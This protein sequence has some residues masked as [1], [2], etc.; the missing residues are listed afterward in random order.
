MISIWPPGRDVLRFL[1]MDDVNS[2]S[3]QVITYRFTRVVFGVSCSPFLLKA[4]L[5]RHIESYSE[6]H[7]EICKRLVNS[8]YV[9]DVN[10]GGYSVEE[11][12][13]LFRVSRQMM[14]EGGFNLRKWL[15]NSKEMMSQIKSSQNDGESEVPNE[16][17]VTE[18]DQSFAKTVLNVS[19]TSDGERVKILGLNWNSDT[20]NIV[21]HLSQLA[22][23]IIERPV[24]K[25][26][27][28]SLIA[29]IFDPLGLITPATTPL[30][31]FLQKLF[32]LKIGWD[33]HLR[34]ELAD[35][36]AK[37]HSHLMKTKEISVPRYHFG[38]LEAKPAEIE[39]CGFCDSSKQSYAAAVYA[40]ITV[41]GKSSVSLV[42]SKSRVAPLAKTTIPRLELLSALILARL[43]TSVK[44]ALSPLFCNV[45]IM[46]CWTDSITAMYWIKGDEKQWKMFVD[47]CVQEIRKLVNKDLWQ[48][49]PGTENPADIPTRNNDPSRLTKDSRWFLAPNG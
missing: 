38:S 17:D 19:E 44:D 5:S 1:W 45:K 35:E 34:G 26:T 49:C 14:Q 25:R 46:R 43:I 9:D 2:S 10:R 21:F 29:K 12:M 24:T 30:K 27:I 20:D 47:N 11:V 8:L 37:L 40:K 32:Q 15:S 31:V 23:T 18:E 13:E 39:L 6:N 28:L 3:P 16:P 4:T 48:H 33:E 42:M 41:E 22:S 7:P 36:W